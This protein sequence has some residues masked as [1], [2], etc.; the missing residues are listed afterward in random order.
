MVDELAVDD[1]AMAVL[2]MSSTESLFSG[3]KMA[4]TDAKWP[5][6]TGNGEMPMPNEI[7]AMLP[8]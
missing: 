8:P 1:V 7:F 6:R 5:K 4:G 2:R 3:R